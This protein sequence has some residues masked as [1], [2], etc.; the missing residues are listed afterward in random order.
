MASG[1]SKEDQNGLI[2]LRLSPL[3]LVISSDLVSI[4]RNLVLWSKPGGSYL[5]L[6]HVSE[7]NPSHVPCSADIVIAYRHRYGRLWQ[8]ESKSGP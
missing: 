2:G 8:E 5:R 1:P 7:A 6:F 3:L 4:G